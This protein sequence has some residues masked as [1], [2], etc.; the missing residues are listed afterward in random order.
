MGKGLGSGFGIQQQIWVAELQT[1]PEDLTAENM[2]NGGSRGSE[3]M[4]PPHVCGSPYYLG[5]VDARVGLWW[6]QRP[7]I[8]AR[9]AEV[10]HNSS[11][12]G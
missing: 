11:C 5:D 9:P 7:F 3:I 10:Q 4:G 8:V 12:R 2:T 6:L 1:A